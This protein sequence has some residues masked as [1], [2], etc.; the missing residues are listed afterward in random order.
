MKNVLV[1]MAILMVSTL[2]N[3]QSVTVRGVRLNGSGCGPATAS[4]VTT[5]DGKTLSIIF[6][7]YLAEIGNGSSNPTAMSV[8]KDCRV[9]IDVDVPAGFQYALEQTDY[10][11]F[12]AM[13]ASAYGYHR[14]V[15]NVPSQPIVSMREA[16]LKGPINQNY[17]VT[18]RQKPGRYI[19]SACNSKT[20]TIDLMSQLMVGYLPNTKDRSIAMINLDTIDTNVSSSFQLSWRR[21]Q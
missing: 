14:F 16:Q 21:C 9:M 10:R 5:A 17:Q 6:D 12:V 3:A 8:Q 20:Q 4:A 18:I 19:Y 1:L 7:N 13:P 15:Q 11:G 2:V